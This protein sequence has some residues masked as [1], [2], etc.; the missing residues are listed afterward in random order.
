M[1]KIVKSI[2]IDKELMAKVEL[3]C[4][5]L[6]RNFSNYVESLLKQEIEKWEKGE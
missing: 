1:K 4:A 6:N 2:T 5:T 3:L